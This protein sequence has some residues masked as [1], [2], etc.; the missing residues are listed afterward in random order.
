[1]ALAAP[2]MLSVSFS[3]SATLVNQLLAVCGWGAVLVLG[4]KGSL[5]PALSALAAIEAAMLMLLAAVLAST[6]VALPL[7]LA[8][9]AGLLLCGSVAVLFA[10]Q[11]G[12]GEGFLVRPVLMGVV[13]AGALSGLVAVV[14]VFF[15]DSADRLWIAHSSLPGRAVG[16]M[17]QPNHL[18]TLLLWGL[19]AL[20][21]LADASLKRQ[22]LHPRRRLAL[23]ALGLGAG[24]LMTL[25]VVLSA[26]RTGAVGF[27]LLSAWG[28][29]DKGLARRVRVSVVLSP[30]LYL[31]FWMLVAAWA[32]HT[33]HTF[34]A[35]ARLAAT[36][37]SSSRF[38]IWANTLEMIRAQ[39][40]WGVGW[41]EFNFAWTLT[42]FPGRPVAFFDHTHNLF[43]QFAVELGLPTALV[44]TGLLAVA[45]IQ[46]F[47]RCAAAP[48]DEGTASRAALMMVL[49][50]GL[51]SL[52]EYPL[53]YAY[54]LLPTAWAFGHA[55]RRP[56]AGA[57]LPKIPPAD[58]EAL[59]PVDRE[60]PGAT[61]LLP[62]AGG[63]MALGAVLAAWEY[64]RVV[65]IYQPNGDGSSLEQ[66]IRAG[67]A[68]GFFGHHADYAAA[69]T[70]EPPA[71]AGSAFQ[72]TTH[73][74]LDT[75][76][77]VA[78]ARALAE[79]GEPDGVD[80]GRY[81]AD[82]LREFRNPAADE[83]FAPCEKPPVEPAASPQPFQ[84]EAP[85]KAWSWRDFR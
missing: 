59:A 31:A 57:A 5:R 46:A 52:L 58:A 55:L 3:P 23:S 77:M 41:G 15:P 54:F 4:G 45:V 35:E 17:R 44:L 67:Q 10:A 51:H 78:W 70:A 81:L 22:R 69:T 60:R 24:A 18:S 19:I 36:D 32:H 71:S 68:S 76:L 9:S 11:Q 47:R 61:W 80:K 37:I 12:G 14:Q 21:P 82:R 66:R 8:L 75:R 33:Q 2:F 63:L 16:N 64:H 56:A 38:A 20:V 83:F 53:W 27:L 50:V 85:L 74:L 28:L 13:A 7:S 30:L 29:L 49:L 34:G 79:S 43:L 6:S 48:G 62:V 73:V 84:C 40:W 72:R 65:L 26:S 25:G 42:P 1:L 39:P